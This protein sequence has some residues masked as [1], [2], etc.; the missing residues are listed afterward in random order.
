MSDPTA[1]TSRFC[2]TV[3]VKAN[4]GLSVATKADSGSVGSGSSGSGV[5]WN[6][7]PG[8]TGKSGDVM[9][10]GKFRSVNG[11]AKPASAS[12]WRSSGSSRYSRVCVMLTVSEAIRLIS[13]RR[14]G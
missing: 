3:C 8:S 13:C 9:M 5:G 4:D 1:S 6:G 2:I 11:T 7:P 12:N 10:S 14:V